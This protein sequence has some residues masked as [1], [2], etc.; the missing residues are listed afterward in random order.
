MV[1]AWVLFFVAVKVSF[2]VNDAQTILSDQSCSMTSEIS[3]YEQVKDE[4]LFQ[5]ASVVNEIRTLSVQNRQDVSILTDQVS[6]LKEKQANNE[7]IFVNITGYVEILAKK[8]EVLSSRVSS[9]QIQLSNVS[10]KLTKF[11]SRFER[12]TSG[13]VC[14]A[15]DVKNFKNPKNQ[16]CI[17]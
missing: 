1:T 4:L 13:K 3:F 8:N 5:F 6:T 14:Q 11:T 17:I 7:K 12:P 10:A 16:N 2:Y 9:I 15:S